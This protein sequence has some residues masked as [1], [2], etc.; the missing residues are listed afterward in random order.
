LAPSEP[1][2][3]LVVGGGAREHAIVQTLARSPQRPALWCT[4]GNP[5]IAASA[6]RLE[7]G[8]GEPG[9]ASDPAALAAAARSN[10]IDLVV[11]GPEAP[12]VAGLADRLA[13]V[14]IRCFGPT[15]DGAR[16]EGSKT[17]CKEIMVAAGVPTAFFA[18]SSGIFGPPSSKY[19]T[20]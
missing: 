12:L 11:V 19:S 18:S 14:G 4:P 2:R 7:V 3:V 8:R 16:L 15:A 17:F 10:S 1:R 5:G 20:A 6:R 13:E 9:D